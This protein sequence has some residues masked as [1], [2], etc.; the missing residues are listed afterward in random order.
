MHILLTDALTCPRCGPEFGLMLLADRMEDRRVVEGRL[1]CANCRESYPI[2]D[3]VADLRFGGGRESAPSTASDGG[4]VEDVEAAVRL[5]AL[6]GL[7][8]V[9]GMALVAGPG[10]RHAA[11]VH[12]LVPEVEVVA[13]ADRPEGLAGRAA[14]VSGIAVAGGR[15]PLRGGALRGA[16]LTGGADDALLREGLRVLAPGARLVVEPASAGTAERLRAL[17]AEV[18]LDQAGAVVARAPGRPVELRYNAVR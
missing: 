9:S 8:G 3:A 14:G 6:M 18:L 1:G 16:A 15:L 2:H 4:A 12:A 11:A 10:A 13:A 5:A 7:S 17:G